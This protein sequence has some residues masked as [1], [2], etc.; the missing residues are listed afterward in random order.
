[1]PERARRTIRGIMLQV[2]E[3]ITNNKEWGVGG[4]VRKNPPTGYKAYRETVG[5]RVP[6]VECAEKTTSP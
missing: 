6:E 3:N 5:S 1:M 2:G 4:M